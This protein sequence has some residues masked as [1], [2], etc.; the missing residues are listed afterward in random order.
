MRGVKRDEVLDLVAYER[1][2]PEFLE[3]TIAKKKP[4]RIF[5]GD[6]LTFIF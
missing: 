2:R 5:V 6:R 1:I 3:L 4:R